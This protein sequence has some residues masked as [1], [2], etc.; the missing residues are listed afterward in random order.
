MCSFYHLLYSEIGQFMFDIMISL[1]WNLVGQLMGLKWVA[2][3]A[4]IPCDWS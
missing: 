3:L 1:I 2:E 4:L